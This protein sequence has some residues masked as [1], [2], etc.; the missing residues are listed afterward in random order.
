[1]LTPHE[2]SEK[3]EAESARLESLIDELTEACQAQA[4]AEVHFKVGYANARLL[5]RANGDGNGRVTVNV[6]DDL[7]TVS[8]EALRFRHIMASSNVMV[9]REALKASAER[10][11]WL[12][13]ESV[14]G[15][16]VG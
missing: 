7:A 9:I 16:N 11:G 2:I 14:S 8:T 6:A 4:E 12:R 10:I 5:A 3:L 1:M 15:R 13:T